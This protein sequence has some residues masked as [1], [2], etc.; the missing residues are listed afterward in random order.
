MPQSE[1]LS[2]IA[3]AKSLGVRGLAEEG[4]NLNNR[5]QASVSLRSMD[6]MLCNSFTTCVLRCYSNFLAVQVL[7]F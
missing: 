7:V 5:L 1:L 3:A 4:V 2:L 6:V